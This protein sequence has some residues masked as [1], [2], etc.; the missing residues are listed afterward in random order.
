MQSRQ[1]NRLQALRAADEFL[2]ANAAAFDAVANS[3]IRRR[4]ARTIAALDAIVAE[5]AASTFAAQGRTS[6]YR[7]LRR[8]LIRDHM[9]PIACIAQADLIPTP[10]VDALRMPKYNW[11][12]ARLAAAAHGM[13]L[14]AAPFSA[15]FVWA[16]LRPGFVQDLAAAADAMGQA[17]TDRALSRGRVTGATTGL[18]ET[19]ASARR[20]VDAI[21]ALL[22]GALV[23]D[24]ALLAAWTHVKRVRNVASRR[25][26]D[27]AATAE[28]GPG[29][30]SDGAAAAGSPD[31][32]TLP[33]D[34]T[35]PA[36]LGTAPAASSPSTGPAPDAEH[37]REPARV[38]DQPRIGDPRPR[39]DTEA[40]RR[41][42]PPIEQP[43]EHR[44]A[45][46]TRRFRWSR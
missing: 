40:A 1:A 30:A 25:A 43:P 44:G 14:A 16:G 2:S 8:A 11:S 19:L 6:R 13:A 10:M 9:A 34:D 22:K 41:G 33:L 12:A 26:D 37:L 32:A 45:F 28:S 21:D 18:A 29:V 36:A 39:A 27:A 31:V 46:M 24:P 17:L 42:S 38:A 4:L 3:G 23:H 7:A 20:L 15:D 35:A 5:Q